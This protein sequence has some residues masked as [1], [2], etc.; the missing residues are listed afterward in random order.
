MGAGCCLTIHRGI[1]PVNIDRSFCRIVPIFRV[2]DIDVTVE[3]LRKNGI[4]LQGQIAD[5]PVYR[6]QALKDFD[7][8]WIEVA[9]SLF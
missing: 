9:T 6:Y 5:A 7:G 8:S 1:K 3:K 2:S 4:D